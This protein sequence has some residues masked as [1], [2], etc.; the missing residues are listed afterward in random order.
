MQCYIQAKFKA[1]FSPVTSIFNLLRPSC[2]LLNRF[3]TGQGQRR[4]NWH[5]LEL[6]DCRQ[7]QT[8]KHI[9]DSCLITK[10]DETPQ[11]W[12]RCGQLAEKYGGN[13][14]RQMNEQVCIISWWFAVWRCMSQALSCSLSL[15]RSCSPWRH[16][17]S[18][19]TGV[20]Y[21]EA[22]INS[23]VFRVNLTVPQQTEYTAVRA[24]GDCSLFNIY[25]HKQ[26]IPAIIARQSQAN[27]MTSLWTSSN[28]ISVEC[29]PRHADWNSLKYS[30]HIP[31]GLKWQSAS[32]SSILDW[33]LSS[34][35][36]CSLTFLTNL[37]HASSPQEWLHLISVTKEIRE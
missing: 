34:W 37:V 27:V 6:C 16:F 7:W 19:L 23:Q 32:F 9:T 22:C 26:K 13:N 5:K 15:S 2:S 3:Y 30:L 35:S 17:N 8:M 29:P 12:W 33:C 24:H 1:E 11:S 25:S 4:A 36:A 14:T 18:R 20:S 10:S 31:W 21:E 28:A